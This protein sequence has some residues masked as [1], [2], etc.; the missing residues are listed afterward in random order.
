MSVAQSNSPRRTIVVMPV[1]S[2]DTTLKAELT[3]LNR[4][5]GH[6]SLDRLEDWSGWEGGCLGVYEWTRLPR[7]G[8]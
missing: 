7:H 2:M 1:T 5:C 8:T 3:A 4:Y 6:L